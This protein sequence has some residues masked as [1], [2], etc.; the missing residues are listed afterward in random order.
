M[1][2]DFG[3][4]GYGSNAMLPAMLR[5]A[6]VVALMGF[7]ASPAIAQM[8]IGQSM[9]Q[10]ATGQPPQPASPFAGV[11]VLATPYLWMP[12]TSVGVKPSNTQIPSASGT[13]D[14]GQLFTHLTWVPF[15]GEVEFRDGP[16]GVMVDYI[17][18]PV[19]AGISTRNILFSGATGGLTIDTGT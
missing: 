16:F 1:R 9:Q 6:S 12:W 2:R 13:V 10:P 4:P 17:H 8:T 18:A 19:R 5:I 3:L 11:Q 15:M 14:F 7:G